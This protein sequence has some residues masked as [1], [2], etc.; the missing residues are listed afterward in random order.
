M[1]NTFA[2]NEIN[3]TDIYMDFFS[4]LF[5]YFGLGPLLLSWIN[6]DP[7]MDKQ[8]HPFLNCGVYTYTSP[9]HLGMDNSLPTA[10]HWVCDYLKMPG[11]KYIHFNRRVLRSFAPIPMRIYQ[12]LS[13]EQHESK[14]TS[15]IPGVFQ[16]LF[17]EYLY[18]TRFIPSYASQSLLEIV[19]S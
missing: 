3:K 4:I 11:L 10:L 14:T 6:F 5:N 8:L 13:W 16:K 12:L 19:Y 15:I 18:F 17:W 1:S 9:N 2:R 7:R